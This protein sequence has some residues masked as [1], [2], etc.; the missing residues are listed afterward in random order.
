MKFDEIPE[1][2]GIALVEVE[3]ACLDLNDGHGNIVKL[4]RL[5]NAARRLF[6]AVGV[7]IDVAAR[8]EYSGET[9]VFITKERS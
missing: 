6:Y 7:A 9:C 1:R 2:L 3:E 5:Q 8:T 4:Q